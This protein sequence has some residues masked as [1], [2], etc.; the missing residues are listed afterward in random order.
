MEKYRKYQTAWVWLSPTIGTSKFA[1]A[2]KQLLG[3]E[4]KMTEDSVAIRVYLV[5]C[6]KK[7]RRKKKLK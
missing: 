4:C 5:P 1:E 2:S 7:Y 3:Q 6:N